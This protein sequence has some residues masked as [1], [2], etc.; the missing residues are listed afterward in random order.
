MKPNT[1]LAP[2]TTLSIFSP[3][4]SNGIMNANGCLERIIDCNDTYQQLETTSL[5]SASLITAVVSNVTLI[6]GTY[7]IKNTP[8]HQ[9]NNVRAKREAISELSEDT[10][11][12]DYLSRR[13]TNSDF[14]RTGHFSDKKSTAADQTDFT[15]YNNNDFSSQSTIGS[16]PIDYDFSNDLD[17]GF[18]EAFS[19]DLFDTS[20]GPTE[21]TSDIS[22]D[23][24]G[25]STAQ[26]VTY[27]DDESDTATN[28]IFVRQTDSKQNG[29]P[30]S[31]NEEDET[32]ETAEGS[33]YAESTTSEIT[34]KLPSGNYNLI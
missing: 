3:D 27:V 7:M 13:F 29:D 8:N 25:S 15:D 32:E 21:A 30:F 4:A 24:E 12:G 34:R 9:N 23:N 22:T 2:P 26:K 33:G 18:G 14:E 19:T 1:S 11:D 17:E 5:S 16:S 6:L 10:R 31:D 20:N 28:D